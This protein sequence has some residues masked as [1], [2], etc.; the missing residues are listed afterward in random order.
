MRTAMMAITTKS[1]IRVKARRNNCAGRI[2]T[3][4]P[5]PMGTGRGAVGPVWAQLHPEDTQRGGE[6]EGGEDFG[7]L[8][9]PL[10]SRLIAVPVVGGRAFNGLHNDEGRLSF[11][12]VLPEPAV[13]GNQDRLAEPNLAARAKEGVGTVV[14]NADFR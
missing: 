1:S 13:G 11:P 9:G 2:M 12:Q 5:D 3:S 10:V 14:E 6:A 7:M 8:G 4:P